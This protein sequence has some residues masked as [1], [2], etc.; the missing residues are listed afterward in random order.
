MKKI[1]TALL[2]YA[3]I[4][5]AVDVL[6]AAAADQAAVLVRTLQ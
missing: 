1:F 5:M 2:F 3:A 6:T 4:I